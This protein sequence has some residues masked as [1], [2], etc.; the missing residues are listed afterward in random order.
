MAMARLAKAAGRANPRENLRLNV[1]TIDPHVVLG[2]RKQPAP[3]EIRAR[4]CARMIGIAS[5]QASQAEFA[6]IKAPYGM[7]TITNWH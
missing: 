1:C 3:G 2:T 7:V 6:Q 5:I 4:I